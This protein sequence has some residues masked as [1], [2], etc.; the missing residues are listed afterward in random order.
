MGQLCDGGG[1]MTV[2]L[3]FAPAAYEG[4]RIVLM[5]GQIQIGAVFP[6]SKD[7][8]Y[9]GIWHWGFWLGPTGG[10]WKGGH[11]KTELA[12]KN[13]VLSEAREWLQKAGIE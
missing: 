11:S 13:A 3:T 1:S 5:L 12:A 10:A 8:A 9:G 6:P 2:N 4:G 7:P